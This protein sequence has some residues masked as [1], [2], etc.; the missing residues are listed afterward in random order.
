MSSHLLHDWAFHE[1]TFGDKWMKDVD[2]CRNCGSERGWKYFVRPITAKDLETT[3]GDMK[4][5]IEYSGFTF[6]DY[7]ICERV[8]NPELCPL[9]VVQEVLES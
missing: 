3:F 5:M 7:S 4:E 1:R 8:E 2:V 6:G 9:K